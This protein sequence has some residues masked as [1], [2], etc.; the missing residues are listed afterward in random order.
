MKS[1]RQQETTVDLREH[2]I[3]DT[4]GGSPKKGNEEA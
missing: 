3:D 2:S 1:K 4:A